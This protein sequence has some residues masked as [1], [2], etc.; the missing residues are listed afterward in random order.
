MINVGLLTAKNSPVIVPIISEFSRAN[1]QINCIIVDEQGSSDDELVRYCDRMGINRHDIQFL[2]KSI[3]DIDIHEVSN[4]NGTCALNLINDHE[5]DI[6]VNAGTPRILN[7]GVLNAPTLG[8][9]NCHP[10][11]LPDFRGCSCV[12]W[13][14][15]LDKKIGNTVHWMTEEIDIGIILAK[16]S[17]NLS[18]QDRYIDARRKVFAAGFKLLAQS[19]SK[20]LDDPNYSSNLGNPAK[21]NYYKPI[22]D[23]L[24]NIVKRKLDD[25]RY[26][27]QCPS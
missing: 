27:Y 17:I 25:G 20:V 5:L 7:S 15:Y 1:I 22:S 3:T 21:G 11:L 8:V 16:E 23:A 12:E 9:I 14:I 4:H 18:I 6:L 19:V 2:D 13:A 10:G 26:K 24:L